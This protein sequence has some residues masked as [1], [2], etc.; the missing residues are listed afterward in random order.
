MLLRRNDSVCS[1]IVHFSVPLIL[2]AFSV[3]LPE[4]G[5]AGHEPDNMRPKVQVV[6]LL[7]VVERLEAREFLAELVGRVQ[8]R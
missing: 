7:I 4:I 2:V 3:I 6:L 5:S 8:V 1:T